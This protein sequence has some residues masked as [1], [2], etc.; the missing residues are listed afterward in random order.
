M[1]PVVALVGRPNVGKSTLFNRLTRSRAALVA[2]VP[3][4]TRDRQYGDG[5]IGDRP[6]LVID[7][8]GIL[9][10][11]DRGTTR[12]TAGIAQAIERQTRQAL[13][14]ADA[15][16]FLVDARAGASP[17]DHDVARSL[18]ALGKPLTL[19]VNKSEGMEPALAVAEFHALGLG[20]PQA[21]SAAH[22]EG[23]DEL[24]NRVLEPL[25]RVDDEPPVGDVPR[26]AMIG[27]PNAGKSTLVNAFLGEERVVVADAPGTTRDAIEIPLERAGMSYILIDT[28][29]VRRRARIHEAVEHFSVVKTLQAIDA[30]NIVILLLDAAEGI[31]EQDASLAGYVMERGR[32]LILGVNKWDLLD[33]TQRA[34]VKR[35]VERKLAFLDYAPVHYISALV[36]SGVGALFGSIDKV[37]ISAFKELSTSRVTRVL[38]AAVAAQAPPVVRGRRIR[39]KFAHQGGKN[40]PVIVVYG[41]QT[42]ALSAAYRRYLASTFRRA[43]RLVGTPVR[44]ECRESENPYAERRSK[45]GKKKR[46]KY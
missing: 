31:A 46:R 26:I 38:E 33:T 23:V 39:L 28:A 11:L 7:T 40:P 9:E 29:G 20:Q 10:P 1:K 32:A 2:D 43:F 19:V 25:L 34:W 42:K 14:E 21:I 6:Y 36:G 16:V 35:E 8:G 4:L 41:T 18:R 5:R 27:R 45:P 12:A 13:A 44:I 30:A 17:I 24:M 22:G 3:G 15:I 37:F